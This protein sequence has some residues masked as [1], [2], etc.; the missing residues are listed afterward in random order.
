MIT[1]EDVLKAIESGVTGTAQA[2]K[3]TS[4]S[5]TATKQPI[6]SSPAPPTSPAT[7]I[8][9]RRKGEPYTDEDASTMRKIIAKKLLESKTLSPHV[10]MSADV[11]LDPVMGLRK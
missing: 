10:Y 5:P 2:K 8:A 9:S 1:K 4:V 11:N 7:P 3:A 6:P